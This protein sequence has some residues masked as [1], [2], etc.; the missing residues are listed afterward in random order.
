MNS[1]NRLKLKK[2]E[3]PSKIIHL[4]YLNSSYRFIISIR[5]AICKWRSIFNKLQNNF[6][7]WNESPWSKISL[8]GK[9]RFTLKLLGTWSWKR[10]CNS[11]RIISTFEDRIRQKKRICLEKK[12]IKWKIWSRINSFIVDLKIEMFCF[13]KIFSFWPFSF[14]RY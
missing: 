1:I 10:R 8:H 7:F 2:N 5:I 12:T 9:P 14:L 6:C 13:R 3:K 11:F 4:I